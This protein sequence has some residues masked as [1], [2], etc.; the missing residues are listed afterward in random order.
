MIGRRVSVLL[1]SL[2][3][4]TLAAAPFA[5]HAQV[6]DM[7]SGTGT[8]GPFS[9]HISGGY[10][11][12]S[13][14]THDYLDN[15]YI[16]KGGVTWRPRPEQ[17]WALRLDGHYSNYDATD[18]L[19]SQGIAATRT[20]IDD[21]EGSTLG[22]D[23]NGVLYV[24]FGQ[25]SRGYLTAGAGID[26]RRIELT[27]TVV[28]GGFFCDGWWGFC[29]FGAVPGDVL[30]S[31]ETTT[32]FAWNGGLGVEWDLPSSQLFVEATYH[33]IET[34][35]PTEYIPIVVGLRF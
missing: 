13:G 29:G 5:A 22:L 31:R 2:T 19:I 32:R 8:E 34:Q 33:R 3:L 16:V 17:P 15:G 9:W 12:T 28:F 35:R 26:R 23:L 6:P 10:S 20:R 25:R 11:V 18:Q 1:S 27:Q 21:G 30:V 24:P 4:A 7:S 14:V